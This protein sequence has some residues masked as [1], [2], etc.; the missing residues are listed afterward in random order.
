MLNVPAGGGCCSAQGHCTTYQCSSRHTSPIGAT[1]PRCDALQK[2]PNIPAGWSD[3]VRVGG[4]CLHPVEH[5]RKPR[6]F[7]LVRFRLWD[8]TITAL[9]QVPDDLQPFS[10]MLAKWGASIVLTLTNATLLVGSDKWTVRSK[11]FAAL[12]S[13]PSL[14][15][16]GDTLASFQS[17]CSLLLLFL[18]GLAIR[19]RFRI[20]GSN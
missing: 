16:L 8:M 9:R 5:S 10:S 1:C 7:G 18:I 13:E 3:I 19:N 6:S 14:G 4:I 11:A 2:A 15:L 17:A 20:G 12:S